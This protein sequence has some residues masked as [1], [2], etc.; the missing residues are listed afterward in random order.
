[1]L[2]MKGAPVASDGKENLAQVCPSPSPSPSPVP[3]LIISR[4]V[5]GNMVRNFPPTD[6]CPQPKETVSTLTL[7]FKLFD[8]S[9]L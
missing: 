6:N 9:A 4:F 5:N 3:S 7:P 2:E 1:V 8:S